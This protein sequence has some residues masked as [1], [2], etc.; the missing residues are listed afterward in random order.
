MGIDPQEIEW[1]PTVSAAEAG[2]VDHQVDPNV[3]VLSPTIKNVDALGLAEYVG[4]VAPTAAVLLVRDR[5][6]DGFL[7]VAVNSGNRPGR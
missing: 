3:F 2:L 4:R 6:V 1:M 7:P 5:D